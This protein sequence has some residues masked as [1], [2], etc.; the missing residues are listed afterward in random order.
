MTTVGTS[1]DQ[2]Y[3]FNNKTLIPYLNIDYTAD[4]SPSS[5]QKFTHISSGENFVLENI[6][7]T[8]HNFH[9]GIGLDLITDKGLN[10]MTKY[11]MDHSKE[12][13]KKNFVISADYKVERK[14]WNDV[15]IEIYYDKK[16]SVNV[17][18]MVKAVE[19]SLEYYTKNF[20]PYTHKQC[21]IIEFPRFSTFAQDFPG[22]M[23]YS[24]AFGFV[25]DLEDEE[26]NNVVD[27]VIAHE[28]APVTYT[29]LTLPTKA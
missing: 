8:T 28:I 11:T 14:K 1:L 24:E 26:K 9:G 3:E 5:S 22:T 10:L 13:K 29:H 16:H 27:A 25:I 18:K 6:N 2:S 12:A 4:V 23:P 20:G 17:N 15:D 21:R 7:N 19:R